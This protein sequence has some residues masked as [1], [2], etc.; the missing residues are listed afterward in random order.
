VPYRLPN[1]ARAATP[2]DFVPAAHRDPA[3]LD[4]A[5]ALFGFVRRADQHGAHMQACAGRVFVSDAQ[6]DAG[7]TDVLGDAPITPHI[8]SS[9][10]PTTFQQYLVQPDVASSRLKHY[11]STPE[12]ETVIRGH[13]LYWHQGAHPDIAMSADELRDTNETQRTLLRPVNP[14]TRFTFT[15][16]FENV[17][18]VELGALLWVL[19]LTDD[20]RQPAGR[21]YRF[22]I[23]MG[24]PLGM[25]AIHLSHRVQLHDRVARYQ[26]LFADP[27]AP[28][29]NTGACDTDQTADICDACVA[30]FSSYVVTHSSGDRTRTGS[31]LAEHPRMQT[32]LTLLRWPGPPSAEEQGSYTRYM[33]I[34]R[35]TLP[36]VGNDENE[37]K[38]RRVL[39]NPEQVVRDAER[40]TK[41]Q[42][43]PSVSQGNQ[44]GRQNR[45]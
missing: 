37:Y 45:R 24:K 25:G 28:T 1:V 40:G 22:K 39:P 12:D 32:L 17:S 8:L 41:Y 13:K 11:G 20:D 7:Q 5:E 18:E 29:W 33:E 2:A 21:R 4:I 10:R 27:A 38:N 15:I 30:A 19:R 3:T 42:D 36:R 16:R 31:Q 44:R 9:P 26:S 34:E 14:R 35:T 6:L 23:G 43:S